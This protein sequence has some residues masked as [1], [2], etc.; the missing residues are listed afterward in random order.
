MAPAKIYS[1]ESPKPL[2]TLISV[3]AVDSTTSASGYVPSKGFRT[4]GDLQGAVV[5]FLIPHLGDKA[6]NMG[7]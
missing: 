6:T 5:D 4:T 1:T 2:D 7:T 3:H